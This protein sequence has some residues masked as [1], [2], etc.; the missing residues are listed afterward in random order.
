MKKASDLISSA[1][2]QIGQPE[3]RAEL[4]KAAK[5]IIDTVFNQLKGI[6]PS[7][8][9][10][11]KDPGV[12]RSMRQQWTQSFIENGI[13]STE[14]LRRGFEQARKDESPFCP[15]VGKFIKWCKAGGQDDAHR[16]NAAMYIPYERRIMPYTEEEYRKKAKRGL[17]QLRAVIKGGSNG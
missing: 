1:E 16:E 17:A 13:S 4:A 9:S 6:Y 7:L 5:P 8:V 2:N 14:Q 15:S 11:L 12:E 10:Q 3:Q